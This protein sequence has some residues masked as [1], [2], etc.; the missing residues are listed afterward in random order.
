MG[1]SSK[2]VLPGAF[3]ILGYTVFSLVVIAALLEFT[4]WAIWSSYHAKNLEGPENQA[5]SPVY[6]GDCM[7]TGILARRILATKIAQELR[8]VPTL[9]RDQL[10][11]QVHQ[12]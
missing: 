7:G 2:G 12:Q 10:A 8:A 6:A 4:S 3:A 5:A 1:F 9:G 11:R